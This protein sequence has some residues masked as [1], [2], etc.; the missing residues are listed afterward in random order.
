MP[1]ELMRPYTVTT[2]AALMTI[3]TAMENATMMEQLSHT[4][5]DQLTLTPKDYTHIQRYAA[6]VKIVANQ[7]KPISNTSQQLSHTAVL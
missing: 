7:E 6:L 5:M 4:D 3:L 1:R 2:G